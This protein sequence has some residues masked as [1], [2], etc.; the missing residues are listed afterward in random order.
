[1]TFLLSK[2]YFPFRQNPHRNVPTSRKMIFLKK[3]SFTINIEAFLYKISPNLP[4][5]KFKTLQCP[6]WQVA[7]VLGYLRTLKSGI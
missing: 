4:V 2:G 7:K 3:P 6:V 5:E 1:M